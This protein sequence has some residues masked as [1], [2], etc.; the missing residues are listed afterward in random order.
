MPPEETS[1]KNKIHMTNTAYDGGFAG[2]SGAGGSQ[3]KG[4]YQ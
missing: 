1:T 3:M 2:A 4:Y